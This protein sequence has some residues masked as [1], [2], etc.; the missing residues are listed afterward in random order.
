MQHFLQHRFV[1]L[2]GS[3][4]LTAAILVALAFVLLRFRRLGIEFVKKI[5]I[6]SLKLSVPLGEATPAEYPNRSRGCRALP[7][8]IAHAFL[9]GVIAIPAFWLNRGN[10]LSYID[11]QY[12]LTLV[13]SQNELAPFNLGFSINPLQGLDDLGYFSNT[14]W[15]PELAVAAIFAEVTWQKIGV[16][17]TAAVEL[18]IAV[19]LLAVWLGAAPGKAAAAGW[20]A[21]LAIAPLSYP[22][23]F[24]GVTPDGP[25]IVSLSVMAFIV[26]VLWVGTG[27]GPLWL[28]LLRAG[29]ISLLAWIEATAF[30]LFCS[31]TVPFLAAFGIVFLIASRH[32]RVEF[33]RKL[34]WAACI[35][36]V[37]TVSGLPQAMLGIA[38]DS[39]FHFFREQAFRSEHPLSD[40]S[41]LFRTH[42]RIS[43]SIAALGLVGALFSFRYGN[44][45][46]R[47]FAGATLV[48]AFLIGASSV[49]YARFGHFP[50][51][52]IYFE[53]VLWPIYSIFAVFLTCAAWQL[54][55]ASHSGLCVLSS[56]KEWPLL[57]F[58][59]AAVLAWHGSNILHESRNSRPNVYPPKPSVI[60]AFLKSEVGITSG[61]LFHGR[62]ATMTGHGL[63]AGISWNEMF[64]LDIELIGALGNE[65]RTI[66]LWYYKIPTLIEFSH[67]IPPLFYAVVTRFLVPLGDVQ[68]RDIVNMRLPNLKILRLLGVRYIVTDGGVTPGTDRLRTLAVPNGIAP[69]AVDEIPHVNLGL[70]PIEAVP[71]VS[72]ND[73]LAWLGREDADFRRTAMLSGSDIGPFKEAH[74]IAIQIERGGWRVRANSDGHSLLVVPFAFSNCLQVVHSENASTPELRRADLLLTG[75]IFDRAL[76]AAV[77]YRQGPFENAECRLNDFS[78]IKSLGGL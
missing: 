38:L 7:T 53:Y 35:L 59:F 36:I 73:A 33:W 11:G 16:Q 55:Q 61:A 39:S 2:A 22:S 8:I 12:L 32:D 50:V 3:Q 1:G 34:F 37:L 30:G 54:I 74:D 52:P 41:L 71:L 40:G 17:T 47:H 43:W 51:I 25:Q 49:T 62:V 31:L 21:V 78:E 5:K 76:D 20:L 64:G 48:V 67:T 14:R 26:V 68:Q 6:R 46:T 77:K 72:T 24:Y 56:T 19:G 70:S 27:K 57:V 69:L 60:T 66:G 15:I 23:L 63:P 13:Q 75:I 18:F 4:L 44:K 29:A 9:V 65:H 45:R 28:D 10:L 42:E 58:P